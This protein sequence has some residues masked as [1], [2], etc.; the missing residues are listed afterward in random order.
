MSSMSNYIQKLET[1]ADLEVSIIRATEINKVLKAIIKLEFI[2]KDE[3]YNFRRR[4]MNIW[5]KWKNLLDSDLPTTGAAMDLGAF[6][7]NAGA[8]TKVESDKELF[9][10]A[11][12]DV[13][14][15]LE[16]ANESEDKATKSEDRLLSRTVAS[17]TDTVEAGDWTMIHSSDAFEVANADISNAVETSSAGEADRSMAG[18]IQV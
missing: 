6:P 10:T 4:S 7:G 3:E 2:P 17:E 18:S 11:N 14:G 1:Y 15:V 5:G 8:N 16:T 13:K 12:D 9:K